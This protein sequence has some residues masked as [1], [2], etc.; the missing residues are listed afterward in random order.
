MRNNVT[1]QGVYLESPTKK[2]L[3]HGQ[4]PCTGIYHTPEGKKPQTA[5]IA[6]HPVGNWAQHYLAPYMAR[7]GYGFLGWNTR[8]QG[9]PVATG[10]TLEHSLIDIGVGVRWLR[11]EAGV[12][13]VVLLGN[14]GGASLMGA[15]QSQAL[16]P[17]ID[18]GS[19]PKD[20]LL[21][22]PPADL[23]I[24]LAAHPGRAT[25]LTEWLDPSVTDENDPLSCDPELDM[26]NPKNGPPYSAEFLQRYRAAQVARNERITKWAEHELRR[27]GEGRPKGGK[28]LTGEG[29]FG[30]PSVDG[31]FDRFF[32]V[33]R[34]FAEPR[35][36][37]LT[38]DPS[39]RPVGCFAGDPLQ[40][41]YSGYGL[42]PV[43]S[44]REWLAM[45]SVS[46]TQVRTDR[47][48]PLIRQPALVISANHDVGCFP[49]HAQTIYDA[50]GSKDKRLVSIDGAHYL[51][52]P[53]DRDELAA[54]IAA[55]L[56][57]H[58]AAP[59]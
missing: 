10:F 23:Y 26:Y 52:G 55:W 50:L 58:G 59:V 4:F 36:V 9:V 11:E 25:V 42:A 28:A 20:L 31:V 34:Q 41:N 13:N 30:A 49:S 32:S 27:I 29:T 53:G 17:N 12:K 16:H 37:D 56:E 18:P 40:S 22:L 24:S 6:S 43:T 47:Q 21:S 7:R 38:L 1:S 39:K 14:S 54:L 5:I 19:A 33:P 51:E 35:F 45:W 3:N 46:R 44:A 8:Y 57:E 2:R 48:L 15:Y